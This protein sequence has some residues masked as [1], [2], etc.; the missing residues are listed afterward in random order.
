M[1]I[2][3]CVAIAIIMVMEKYASA[4]AKASLE[5]IEPSEIVQH[6]REWAEIHPLQRRWTC[7]RWTGDLLCELRCSCGGACYSGACKCHRCGRGD[8][9]YLSR[10]GESFMGG[11]VLGGAN[12]YY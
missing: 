12:Y 2:E 9:P 7:N 3:I 6:E 11:L 8:S 10:W 1:R 5:N 4:D